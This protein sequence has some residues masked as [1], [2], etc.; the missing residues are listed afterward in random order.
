MA[1][2]A[3]IPY[4]SLDPLTIGASGD[5]DKVTRDTL[6]LA[7]PDDNLLAAIYPT[8]PAP[9]GERDGSGTLRARVAGLGAALLRPDRLRVE[10]RGDHRQPVPADPAVEAASARARRDRSRRQA[11]RG[12]VRE[13]EGLPDVRLG[14][15]PE[16]RQ[17]QPRSHG[18]PGYRVPSERPAQ[19]RQLRVRRRLLARHAGVAAQGG[20]GLRRQG[21]DRPGPVEPLGRR[22]RR[23]AHPPRRRLRRDDRVEP[24]R[25]RPVAADALRRIRGADALGHR[26]GRDDV[27]PLRRR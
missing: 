16:D 11:G 17:G 2:E 15:R 3:I 8:E 24:L 5:D 19:H 25:V 26:R 18:A 22:R 4:E 20:R 27:R 14:H 6:S 9:V 12:R 13:R 1:Y 10:G 23:Q 21:H 7:I